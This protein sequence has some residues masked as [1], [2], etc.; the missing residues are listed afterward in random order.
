MLLRSLP[1]LPALL[2]FLLLPPSLSFLPPYA[3]SLL[4][5]SFNLQS[6]PKG[7]SPQPRPEPTPNDI[8]IYDE[9]IDKLSMATIQELPTAVSAAL[10]VVGSPSFFMRIGEIEEM[11]IKNISKNCSFF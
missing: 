11:G 2:L 10:K 3:R 5:P 9:M 7:S 1:A 4:R 8:A 6:T